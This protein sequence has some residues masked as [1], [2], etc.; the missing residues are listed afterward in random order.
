L[1]VQQAA[2]DDEFNL[3]GHGLEGL[4]HELRRK[5]RRRSFLQHE[6]AASIPPTTMVI[7]TKK[8]TLFCDL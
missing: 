3:V 7:R 8:L 1:P 5:A 2:Q 4:Y 6:N